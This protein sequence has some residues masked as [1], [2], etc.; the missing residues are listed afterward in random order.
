MGFAPAENGGLVAGLRPLQLLVGGLG[1]GLAVLVA[2]LVPT[3]V[4]PL[5]LLPGLA[6][7]V[8]ALARMGASS[9]SIA[10]SQ[11]AASS[12]VGCAA[13]AIAAARTSRGVPADRRPDGTGRVGAPRA[14]GRLRIVSHEVERGSVGVLL[15]E[16]SVPPQECWWR[17]RIRRRCSTR[18]RRCGA[19]MSSRR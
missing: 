9:C 19:R 10:H 13:R 8:F 14:W 7:L 11:R 6:L 2:S 18:P 15:D 17:A 16:P 1:A 3:V 4:A 12:R 5:A